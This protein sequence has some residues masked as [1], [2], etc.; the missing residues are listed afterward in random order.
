MTEFPTRED[1][2]KPRDALDKEPK[3]ADPRDVIGVADKFTPFIYLDPAML[4]L[5]S[6]AD[7]IA[8]SD[9]SILITGESGTG[10]EVLARHLHAKSSRAERQFIA[11]SCAAIPEGLLESELFGHEMGAFTGAVRRSI[12]KFEQAHGGT[13][14]L[15]EVSE[16]PLRLQAKL[17]RAVQEREINRVGGARPIKVDIRLLAISNQDLEE[18]VRKGN[19]RE[20]LYFRLSVAQIS[21]PPLRERLGDIEVLSE[22][23]IKKYAESNGLGVPALTPE[24]HELIHTHHWPGNVR[25]LE[26][27]MHRAVLLAKDN[28]ITADSMLLSDALFVADDHN[29]AADVGQTLAHAERK[30]ILETLRHCRGNRTLA[31][32][33]LG[34]SIRTLRNKLKLYKK[35]GVY[36]R[37]PRQDITR[38]QDAEQTFPEVVGGEDNGREFSSDAVKRAESVIDLVRAKARNKTLIGPQPRTNNAV[39]LPLKKT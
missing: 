15:D 1:F 20:D 2:S 23:F 9:A 22:Y 35:D 27:A 11:L 7:Q 39:V 28:A 33:I 8:P 36:I 17:L 13:L 37:M 38:S 16:M 30:L 10:K 14:L 12:G 26:N 25:E 34:I 24:A 21:L 32:N 29:A 19:F 5:L 31:A 3:R 18:E 4:D 6:L